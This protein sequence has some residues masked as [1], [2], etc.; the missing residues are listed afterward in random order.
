MAGFKDKSYNIGFETGFFEKI[1]D[2]LIACSIEMKAACL[3]TENKLFNNENKITNRLTENHLNNR[4]DYMRFINQAPENYNPENDTHKGI[5][6]L[7]VVSPN[8]FWNDSIYYIVECKRIDGNATLN[9]EY[10][11]NGVARFVGDSPKYTSRDKRNIMFGYIV[12]TV[13]IPNNVKKIEDLQDRLL[14]N[15]AAGKFVLTDSIDSECY[16]YSCKY[17]STSNCKELRHLFYDFSDVM[18]G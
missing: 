8:H 6:D 1:L 15:V 16:I 9:K 7:K 10:V 18:C 3:K 17:K 5:V 13:D 2:Q 12:N 11:I 4:L 14:P